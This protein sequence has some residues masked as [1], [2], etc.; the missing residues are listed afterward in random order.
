MTKREGVG[1]HQLYSPPDLGSGSAL[2]LDKTGL[3]PYN[4]LL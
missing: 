4:T 1:S 3:C 2:G